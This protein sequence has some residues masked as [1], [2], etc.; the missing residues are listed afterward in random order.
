MSE[1]KVLLTGVTGFIGQK[2]LP[3]LLEAGHKVRAVSRRARAQL[4]LPEHP[5]LEVFQGDAL[6]EEDLEA[7]LDGVSAAFYLIHSMEGGV[8]EANAFIERDKQA[9]LN[10]SKAAARAKLSQII[11]VSGLKPEQEVSA[12][13]RSRNDVEAYL[14]EHGVPVTV[15]RAGFIIGAGSAGFSM[16]RGLTNNMT[17]MMIPTQ[18]HHR[19]QPAY[20]EDVVE[21]LATCLEH[22]EKARGKVFEVGSREIVE[23]FDIIQDFCACAGHAMTFLEVPWVPQKIAATYISMVSDLP[24]ALVSALSEG[25]NIDLLVTDTSLYELFPHIPRTTPAEA[26]RRA[27]SSFDALNSGSAQSPGKGV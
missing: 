7:M 14:G 9:A 26:M 5:N 8:T 12:H 17:T 2:L 19:T 11:Y 22:P 3:R 27:F 24:Y 1:G 20:A 21:A 4:N 23:Y 6:K 13:L 15:L 18:M 10:F 25:L 16:L